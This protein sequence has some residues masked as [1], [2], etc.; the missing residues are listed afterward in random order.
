MDNPGKLATQGTQDEDK[1]NKHTT[2]YVCKNP[3]QKIC[4]HLNY[5]TVNDTLIG[6]LALWCIIS[7]SIFQLYSDGQF[8][9]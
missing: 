1:Q 4:Q 9:W 2:Q 5:P 6:L 8:Y 7:L 3:D